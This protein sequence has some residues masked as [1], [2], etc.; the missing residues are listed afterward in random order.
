[1]RNGR[2]PARGWRPLLLPLLLACTACRAADI[3]VGGER[4]WAPGVEYADVYARP[5]DVLVGWPPRLGR[6]P[7]FP[8]SLAAAPCLQPGG[9]CAGSSAVG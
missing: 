2:R 1:M 6:Q 3:V 9:A 7:A 4:G 8:I 5:G